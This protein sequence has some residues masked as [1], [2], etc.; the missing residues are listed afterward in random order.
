MTAQIAEMDLEFQNFSKTTKELELSI[1]DLKSKLKACGKEIVKERDQIKKG[2]TVIK[3][4]QFDL[5]ELQDNFQNPKLLKSS[6]KK[7]YQRYCKDDKPS[8]LL[9]R[10]VQEEYK[11]QRE[12]LE[13]S[14]DSLQKNAAKEKAGYQQEKIRFLQENVILISEMNE[15]LALKSRSK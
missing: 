14:I 12:Y 9:D 10:D 3:N 6:L 5:Q 1:A 4:F 13:R 2:E 11:R 15:I 8:E 7:L